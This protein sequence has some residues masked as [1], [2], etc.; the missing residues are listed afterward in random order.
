MKNLYLP[1]L[2]ML[3]ASC[4]H[5]LVPTWYD[6]A[7][8]HR[9]LTEIT[10]QNVTVRLENLELREK[11]MI[12]DMEILNGTSY[13]IPI[14]LS[15]IYCYSSSS[16]FKA[17]GSQGE[18]NVERKNQSHE[19]QLLPAVLQTQA[20]TLEEVNDFYEQKLK[21]KAEVGVLLAV[22]GA[23]LIIYDAV[24]DAEDYSDENWTREK[25]RN[26]ITRDLVT[27][28]SL[29]AMSVVSDINDHEYVKTLEDLE[30]LPQEMLIANTVKQGERVRGKIYVR[31]V[32]LYKYYRLIV[33]FENVSFV[34]DLRR[35]NAAERQKIRT[36]KY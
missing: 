5:R 15:S 21:T 13:D 19:Q 32:Y 14:D 11:Y 7:T 28:S 9:P 18:A 29:A 35:A 12:F 22:L 1:G 30:Y 4:T 3:M 25:E 8:D 26:S 2:L 20:M 6:V 34:F 10:D 33:P 23:G 36:P 27:I 17:I 24:M 16:K 31:N